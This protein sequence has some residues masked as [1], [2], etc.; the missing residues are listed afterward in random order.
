MSG[1]TPQEIVHE[2]DKYIVGQ[3][4]RSARSP[5]HFR[6]RWRRQQ[7]AEPMRTE[8]TPKNIL[9]I[10]DRR[11]QD[12]D[13]APPRAPR[14]SAVHQGRGHQVH[15]GRLRRARR[16]HHRARPGGDQR[17]ADA[18]A[19]DAPRARA[20]PGRRRGA[21]SRRPGGFQDGGR[22]TRRGRSSASGC[23]RASSTTRRS[24]S[25]S[26]RP[27]RRWRSR[28]RRDGGAHSQIQGMLSPGQRAAAPAQDEDARSDAGHH[29]G[30]S[31]AP[32]ERRRAQGARWPTRS[33]TA[34]CSSTRST[35]SPAAASSRARTCRARAC[36][37]TC[38][39][40]SRHHRV[41]TLRH[42]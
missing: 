37:A 33:R 17:Q 22:R 16:R 34:S 1:M 15:R 35:R 24:T 38:C 26:P 11:R 12:R 29:R 9:M 19:G 36:S 20:R 28:R 18:R 31:R 13:R 30:G 7:V 32:G 23:A 14:R 6:N 10:P 39:R 5:L 3:A 8:I 41:D 2:L 25:R 4:R 42:G 27:S 21:H 40:R